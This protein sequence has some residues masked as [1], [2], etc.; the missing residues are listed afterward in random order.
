MVVILWVSVSGEILDSQGSRGRLHPRPC[1]SG[2]ADT[3]GAAHPFAHVDQ[4]HHCGTFDHDTSQASGR[5]GS[6]VNVNPI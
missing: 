6:R 5:E 4:R 1:I 2:N 3:G